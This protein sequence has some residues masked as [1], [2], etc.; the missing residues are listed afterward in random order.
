M[1]LIQD[2]NETRMAQ[3]EG[4]LY[5][6]H[7]KLQRND[8]RLQRSEENSQFFYV[9]NQVIMDTLTRSLQV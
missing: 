2:S 8:E 3:V 1:H 4:S 7:L 5:D 6:L 9:R